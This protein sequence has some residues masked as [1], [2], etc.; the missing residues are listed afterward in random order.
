M[1]RVAGG[2]DLFHFAA[3]G[4]FYE[5]PGV[6]EVGRLEPTGGFFAILEAFV[7]VV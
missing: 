5:E 6:F 3:T 7:G 4:A 2:E 1:G